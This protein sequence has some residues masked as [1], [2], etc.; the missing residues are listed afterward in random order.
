MAIIRVSGLSRDFGGDP[1]LKNIELGVET[2]K[3]YGL[4]GRNGCG[5]TTFLKILAGLDDDYRGQLALLPHARIAYVPQMA[6]DFYENESC[7][8]FLCRDIYAMQARLDGFAHI[9]GSLDVQESSAAMRDYALVR[10]SFDAVEGDNCRQNADRLL[11]RVGLANKGDNPARSLSGGEKNIVSLA[12]ALLLRPDLLILDEPGNHLDTAGLAWLE[13]F[14][15]GL[16]HAVLVVSHDRRLLDK[17]ADIIL[18]LD[19]AELSEWPG[20]YSNY[21]LQKLRNA[22]AQGRQWQADKRHVERLEEMVRR[23]AEIARSRPDPGWG[24]RLR[25]GRSKLARV[26]EEATQRP[27]IGNRDAKVTFLGDASKADIAA[28]ISGYSKAFGDTVLFADAGFSVLNGERVALLGRNGSGK[29]SFLRD[30]V[31]DGSWDNGTLKVGPSMRLGYCSQQQELFDP[32]KTVE[33]EF[34]K[35]LPNSREVLGHLGKFLFDY[36]ALSKRISQLSGGELNRLQLARSSAI[37]ANFLVLDE[38][39]NHLDIPTREAVED[40]LSDFEGT[41]LVVSHDRYFLDKIAGRVVFIEERKFVEYEGNFSEYWRDIGARQIVGGLQ[42]KSGE[43]TRL[44]DRS[45]YVKNSPADTGNAASTQ[46]L[47]EK[48]NTMERGKEEFEK[49]MEKAFDAR[50]YERAR[51]LAKNLEEHNKRLAELWKR[52]ETL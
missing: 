27:D 4:V 14:L 16:P 23:F 33:D 17:V 10:E 8:D 3:K 2:G 13:E 6:P 52:L 5:K 15:A 18:E 28:V 30:L 43:K 51:D 42:A 44:E 47:E 26:R 35:I 40:A 25:A 9:M 50:D 36:N 21:R 37:K 38:P 29:T 20:N 24:K 39:T 49:L 12:R 7:A 48:I 22:A 31:K 1:I 46:A 19:K 11:A 41:I 45:R 32:G 34:L